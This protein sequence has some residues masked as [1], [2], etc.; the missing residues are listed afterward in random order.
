MFETEYGLVP[1]IVTIDPD[2]ELL[3]AF[4]RIFRHIDAVK[5][6]AMNDPGIGLMTTGH[7]QADLVITEI[8]Y[9]TF[10]Y[11]DP[12]NDG[13]LIHEI[14]DMRPDAKIIVYSTETREKVIHR[15]LA[16]Y[17][18]NSYFKKG[19]C[20]IFDLAR[21]VL[22]LLGQPWPVEVYPRKREVGKTN[23]TVLNIDP[24]PDICKCIETIF[25]EE[26]KELRILTAQ[27]GEGGIKLALENEIDVIIISLCLDA[28]VK[29]DEII[30]EIKRLHPG[31]KVIISS[32][33]ELDDFY[34]WEKDW[35]TVNR[36]RE[37]GYDAYLIKPWNPPKFIQVVKDVLAKRMISGE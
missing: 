20:G 11:H 23:P 34:E 27:N 25:E 26:M 18:V 29:G 32:G 13:Y 37:A 2:R 33:L 3:W 28:P 6:F 21:K 22:E 14:R 19:D 16:Q 9:P 15:Y 8:H 4:R 24:D 31:I 17:G 7:Y 12:E 5:F 30:R 10:D 35:K 1:S 36:I